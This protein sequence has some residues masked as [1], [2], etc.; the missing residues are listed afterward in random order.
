MHMPSRHEE[1][2]IARI[3]HRGP[4]SLEASFNPTLQNGQVFV[5]VLCFQHQRQHHSPSHSPG[6]SVQREMNML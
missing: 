5:V 3:E 2:F 4:F 1:C 6:F